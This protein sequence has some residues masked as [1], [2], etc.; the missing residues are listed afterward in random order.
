VI[1]VLMLDLSSILA[2]DQT[3]FPHVAEALEAAR[4][5]HTAAGDP[6]A[7]CLIAAE[8]QPGAV[9]THD[10][11]NTRLREVVVLLD[12]LD[13][14]RFFEPVDRYITLAVHTGAR[15]PDRDVF[16]GAI[17]RAG[18][19]A[20]LG[21][22]LF[23]ARDANYIAAGRSYG[24]RALRFDPEGAPGADFGDWSEAPLLVVH[25]TAPGNDRDLLVALTSRLAVTEGLRPLSI[26]RRTA[27]GR[28]RARA[29]LLHPLPDRGPGAAGTYVEVPVS[30]DIQLDGQGRIAA[31]RRAEPSAED[32]AEATHLIETLEANKQ[33][34]HTE[35][36]L[37]PGATHQLEVDAEGRRV[38][39]RKRFS[40]T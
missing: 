38:V 24:M 13:L 4:Q 6:L 19:A 18:I 16:E 8:Q 11:A 32:L 35:G 34:A 7:V 33:I 30:A 36:S 5:L 40:A 3:V 1:R 23:I 12:A 9:R 29:R 27:D 39:K 14:T 26:D 2:E 31:V 15:I 22:C 10:E 20:G 37:P 25:L 21:E 28:I 17:E